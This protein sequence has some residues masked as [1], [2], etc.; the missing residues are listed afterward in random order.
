MT[1]MIP[2]NTTIPTSKSQ[3][4][5]TAADNQP[6]VDIHVLQGE[7]G[8][9]ADNK[10]LGNFQLGNIAPAPRGVPQIE[11]TFDIDANGIVNV[12][13]KDLAT[14]KEQSI[15]ITSNTSLSDEEIDKMVKEAEANKEEDKRRKELADT[16][17]EIEQLIYATE[18]AIKD[19]GDKVDEK[20]KTNAEDAIKEAKDALETE[21]ID[22]LKKAK[23]NLND[24]AM[25]LGKKV[26]EEAAKANQANESSDE[27]KEDKKDNVQEAEYEEK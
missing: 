21:D 13:A 5:S 26:Y 22:K 20:D 12:K 8:M 1:V 27:T 4:F 11:V 7:R 2:R 17:N 3:I 24:K 14:N 10:T 15:T 16:K 9:A 23:E 25:E 18:K 19:L 6:A